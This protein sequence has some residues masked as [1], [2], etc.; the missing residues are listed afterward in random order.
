MFILNDHL[1]FGSYAD[2]TTP[3]VYGGNFDEILGEFE[4]HMAKNFELFLHNSPKASAKNFH[5]FLSPFIDKAINIEKFTIK[6]TIPDKIF[7]TKWSN[8]AKLDRK[9][10]AINKV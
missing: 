10:T 8:P 2:G 4:K 1:K 7:G 6:A 5:L 3:F 9:R